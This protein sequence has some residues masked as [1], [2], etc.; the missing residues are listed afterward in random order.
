MDSVIDM[1]VDMKKMYYAPVT[2]VV[3]LESAPIM[4]AFSLPTDDGG[5]D[6]GRGNDRYQTG[7]HRGDWSGIW[8]GM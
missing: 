4:T 3:E 8:D 2:E 1:N 5:D 6:G 7:E